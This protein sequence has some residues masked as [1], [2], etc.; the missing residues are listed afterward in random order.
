MACPYSAIAGSFMTSLNLPGFSLTLLLLPRE[1]VPLPP[2][3]A[4]SSSAFAVD[5]NLLLELFD[6]STDAPAWKWSF[7]GEPDMLVEEEDGTGKDGKKHK[8]GVVG[9]A[10]ENEPGVKGPRREFRPRA[11]RPPRFSSQGSAIERRTDWVPGV[12]PFITKLHL[13]RSGRFEAV[14][15][16]A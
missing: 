1:P 13:I 14:P 12:A 10:D 8:S 15:R 5:S 11:S 6:A 3:A 4:S 7:K 16:C 9:T 2:A